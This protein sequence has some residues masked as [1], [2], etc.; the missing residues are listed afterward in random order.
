M[1]NGNGQQQA[2]CPLCHGTRVNPYNTNSVCPVCEGTGN[3]YDPGREYTYEMG[4]L[5]LNGLVGGAAT[6]NAQNAVSLQIN[7]APFRWMFLL[8]QSTFPFTIQIKDGTDSHNPF[9]N[10]QVH[11]DN[12]AGNG[13]HPMPLL[14]PFVFGKTTYIEAD[15]TDLGGAQGTAGVTNGSPTV[16]LN[17]GGP[18]NTSP[19]TG[20]PYS[21]TPMWNGNTITI[22]G[23][24]Y[25]ISAVTSQNQLTL[26][27]NYAGA[28]A[29]AA[30]FYV[31]NNIRVAFKGVELSS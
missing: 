28:T 12:I 15:F 2:P 27:M 4:P 1:S 18:F 16:T 26:A 10:Q 22:A 7:R 9:S 13:T 11:S 21:N 14:T 30:A 19:F 25:V 20:A 5:I 3:A 23:V 29:A 17:A 8:K 6:P 31:P 24:N